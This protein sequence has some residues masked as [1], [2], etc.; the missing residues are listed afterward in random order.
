MNFEPFRLHFEKSL[1][2]ELERGQRLHGRPIE[3]TGVDSPL[4]VARFISQATVPDLWAR[5]HLAI[6][7]TAKEAEEL[8]AQIAFFAPDLPV[9]SLPA[10][11][12]SPFSALYPNARV[13]SARARWLHQCGRERGRRLFIATAEALM[14]RTIPPGR[15]QS[16]SR[17]FRVGD[18]LPT[19]L[20]RYLSE[21]GYQ[22]TPVVE[23]EGTFAIRGG[24]VDIFS[25][26]HE[27]PARLG[28]FGDAIETLR[29]S[30]PK[31]SVPIEPPT[32]SR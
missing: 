10:F 4:A 15:M 11:D 22:A 16:L 25:P 9:S 24:I 19:E 12:V 13:S 14:Q 7:A 20:A 27:Q 3:V 5:P 17:R 21:I 18:E 26:A 6:V 23:D 28:L 32:A 29:F 31:P 1:A 2:R 8:E 30:I